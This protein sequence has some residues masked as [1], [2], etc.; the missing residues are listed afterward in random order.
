MP[1]SIMGSNEKCYSLVDRVILTFDRVFINMEQIVHLADVKI[2]KKQFLLNAL[3]PCILK[4]EMKRIAS[5]LLE[6]A[7]NETGN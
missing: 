5:S 3:Y 6:C 7:T 2:R 4:E 1:N